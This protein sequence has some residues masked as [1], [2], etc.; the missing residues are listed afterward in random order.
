MKIV[1]EQISEKIHYR[2]DEEFIK[3]INELYAC[4]NMPIEIKPD[5]PDFTTAIYQCCKVNYWIVDDY[6]N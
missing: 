4:A 2:N 1:L 3:K 6:F 5:I